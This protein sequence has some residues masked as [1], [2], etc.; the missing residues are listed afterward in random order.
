M[1]HEATEQWRYRVN[2]DRTSTGKTSFGVTAEVS[3][4]GPGQFELAIDTA[5]MMRSEIQAR[6]DTEDAIS[7]ATEMVAEPK[8]S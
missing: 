5:C 2:I 6:L 1:E 4:V 3:G 7:R 8:E